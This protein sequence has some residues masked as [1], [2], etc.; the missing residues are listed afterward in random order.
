[1]DK[2]AT[3]RNSSRVVGERRRDSEVRGVVGFGYEGRS[4]EDLVAFA[5]QAGF[6]SV[7]D[8]RLTPISR[9]KGFSKSALAAELEKSGIAYV[10][11][12]ALGNPRDNRA[13]YARTNDDAGRRAR[14][15]YA[16]DVLESAQGQAAL[17]E[18][19][20]L[21]DEGVVLLCFEA[22][23]PLCHRGDVVAALG[24]AILPVT[25]KP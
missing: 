19:R 22:D 18:V 6:A 10:H 11:L 17:V 8:V 20:R 25:A 4:V 3:S 21:A 15:R 14:E 7:V 13:G 5:R 16:K 24:A 2:C 12:P 1:M 23:E 9:R